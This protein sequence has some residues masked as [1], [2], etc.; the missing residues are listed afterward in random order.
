MCTKN[1]L[2]LLKRNIGI[3]SNERQSRYG[4]F[5]CPKNKIESNGT[6]TLQVSAA[7]R[8]W[9]S[10]LNKI[11]SSCCLE[12]LKKSLCKY[13][14]EFY[15][16]VHPFTISSLYSYI[17]FWFLDKSCLNCSSASFIYLYMCLF[18]IC[19]EGLEFI[20][21]LYRQVP[22]SKNE[23]DYYYDRNLKQTLYENG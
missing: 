11:K 16:D 21:I 20:T 1:T 14:L 4:S 22:H 12:I 23:V 5:I 3:S 9:N 7:I 8:F 13:V 19:L 18:L 2:A 17:L 6:I 10:L 15:K